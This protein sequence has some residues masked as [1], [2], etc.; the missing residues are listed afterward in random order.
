M[1]QKLKGVTFGSL[2]NV[3]G[4]GV[5]MLLQLSQAID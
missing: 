5:T 3:L 2:C 1:V 4:G